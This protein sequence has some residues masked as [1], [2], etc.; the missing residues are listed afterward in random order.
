MQSECEEAEIIEILWKGCT[1]SFWY[2]LIILYK[3][4][5][6]WF[7]KGYFH[8]HLKIVFV[9]TESKL[10]DHWGIERI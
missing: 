2:K 6:L 7:T 10:G 3:I 5:C 9:S 8:H 4:S 1:S